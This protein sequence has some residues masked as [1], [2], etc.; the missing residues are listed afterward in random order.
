MAREVAVARWVGMAITT[1][2]LNMLDLIHIQRSQSAGIRPPDRV[3]LAR[4]PAL[5]ASV[6]GGE[7]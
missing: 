4:A 5:D 6:S 1:F 3:R 7:R 2:L